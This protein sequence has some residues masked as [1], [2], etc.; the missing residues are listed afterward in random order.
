[1]QQTQKVAH[2]NRVGYAK[3]RTNH[4]GAGR[5]PVTSVARSDSLDES[6]MTHFA[7]SSLSP[8]REIALPRAAKPTVELLTESNGYFHG[9][10]T[11]ENKFMASAFVA[12]LIRYKQ[13]GYLPEPDIIVAL[14]TDEEI[15][16]CHGARHALDANQRQLIDA[17]FVLN[18]GGRGGPE[19]G[20]PMWNSV[21]TAEKVLVN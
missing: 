16:R 12:N 8:M 21:Q 3:N 6:E 18:E 10:G 1:M 13:E 9:R 5:S 17:K 11:A 15:F 19:G 20:K 4:Y 7:R 14:E 2:S